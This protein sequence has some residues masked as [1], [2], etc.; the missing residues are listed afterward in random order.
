MD[1]SGKVIVPGIE[2][3]TVQKAIAC[4]LIVLIAGMH[5]FDTKV[6]GRVQEVFTILKVR[7]NLTNYD[8]PGW[9]QNPPGTVTWLASDVISPRRTVTDNLHE[10]RRG[11]PPW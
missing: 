7:E 4:G 6:G 5:G 10:I 1:V 3:P 8:D 9:Y 2:D 11:P